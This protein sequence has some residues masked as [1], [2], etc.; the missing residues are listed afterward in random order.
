MFELGNSLREARA[1]Q[2]L[3]YPQVE[4]ATKVRAKY[5]RA[6]EEE[7]FDVLPAETYVKGFLR[8]YADFLG[9]DG[10]LYVDE[11]ES[12]FVAD[13]FVDAPEHRQARHRRR[14]RELSFERRAVV[15][16]L[17]GMAALAALVIVAW[18]FGAGSPS[19]PS[20]LPPQTAPQGLRFSGPGTYIVVRRGS[21]KGSVLYA[22]TLRAGETNL[23]SGSRFWILVRHPS[24]LHVTLDGKSVSLPSRKT[25][26][27]VV[28]PSSTALAG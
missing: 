16:A 8:A 12:R 13:A 23:V 17:V 24:G 5:I 4:L 3:G 2:G 11:Y 10:Q 22:G 21:A 19:A 26:A 25:L 7:R 18:K 20:V 28:T 27:V 6:L 14:Q 1:R 9:L 15:L